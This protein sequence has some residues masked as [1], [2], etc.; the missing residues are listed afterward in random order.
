MTPVV[1]L[2]GLIAVA[3]LFLVPRRVLP[4]LA[5][6]ALVL[7]PVGFM[8][9]SRIIGRYYTPAVVIIL[10]WVLRL[11]FAPRDERA[12]SRRTPVGLLWLPIAALIAASVLTSASIATSINWL[13]VVA[14]TVLIPYLLGKRRAEDIWPQTQVVLVLVACFLGMLSASDYLFSFNPWTALFSYDVNERV[15]S[16]FRTRTSLGHPLITAAVA[17]VC[18]MVALFGKTGARP[19]RIAGLLGG[20]AA[21]ILAVSRTSVLAVAVGVSVGCLILIFGPQ[22]S[23]RSRRALGFLLFLAGV[24]FVLVVSN[25]PLLTERNESTGGTASA[26]YRELSSRVAYSLIAEH[27]AL[28]TGPGTSSVQFSNAYDGPLENSAL[29]LMLSLGVPLTITVLASLSA[30]MIRL[31]LRG[32]AVL[33]ALL[34]TFSVS[35]IGFSAIDVNPAILALISP[36]VYRAGQSISTPRAGSSVSALQE[37]QYSRRL[38]PAR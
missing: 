3:A 13:S 8:D 25:S 2:S 31:A 17:S 1:V 28:G 23:D 5:I 36:A 9:L 35:L 15:W 29:Q 16:I 7:L 37:L 11:I 18:V 30:L 21:L 6:L 34:L 38:R 26:Q 19:L 32:E 20:G 4:I 14:I 27:W 22:T 12:R 10:V 24:A 33:V